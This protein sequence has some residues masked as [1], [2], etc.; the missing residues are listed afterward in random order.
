MDETA[1]EKVNII[2]SNKTHLGVVTQCAS[3]LVGKRDPNNRDAPRMTINYIEKLA[4]RQIPSH[5]LSHFMSNQKPS[6]VVIGC[7]GCDRAVLRP[8]RHRPQKHIWVLICLVHQDE[9]SACSDGHDFCNNHLCEHYIR[10]K[11]QVTT[12]PK[13]W[14]YRGHKLRSECQPPS[15]LTG[16][17]YAATF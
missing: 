6:I 15:G 7:N 1:T 4:R 9:T 14:T 2:H 17:P 12:D 13:R 11:T 3:V 10:E 16:T 8:R 5:N